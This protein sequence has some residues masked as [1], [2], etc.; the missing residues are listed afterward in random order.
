MKLVEK[1]KIKRTHEKDHTLRRVRGSQECNV[2]FYISYDNTGHGNS[3]GNTILA[4]KIFIKLK[5]NDGASTIN[6]DE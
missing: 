3:F 5:T 2:N 4:I 6:A 1:K